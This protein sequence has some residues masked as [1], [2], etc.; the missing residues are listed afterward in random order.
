MNT[1]SIKWDKWQDDNTYNHQTKKVDK[2]A[3]WDTFFFLGEK[4]NGSRIFNMFVLGI[5]SDNTSN[6]PVIVD[7]EH[8]HIVLVYPWNYNAV[9]DITKRIL[10]KRELL[11]SSVLEYK[12]FTDVTHTFKFSGVPDKK[13]IPKKRKLISDKDFWPSIELYINEKV[14]MNRGSSVLGEVY[15]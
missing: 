8:N 5:L 7:Y 2:Y 3:E 10:K 13:Y 9:A 6:W 1:L 15:S 4:H 14:S 12:S 11:P